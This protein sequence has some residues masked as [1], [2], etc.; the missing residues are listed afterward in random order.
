[1]EIKE[2]AG[3]AW[4]EKLQTFETKAEAEEAK[5]RHMSDQ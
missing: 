4:W 5:W 1:M 3:K 2:V